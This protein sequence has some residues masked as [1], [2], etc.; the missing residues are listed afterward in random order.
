MAVLTSKR[1]NL[2]NVL[3]QARFCHHIADDFSFETFTD[4]FPVQVFPFD[5]F[6]TCSRCSHSVCLFFYIGEMERYIHKAI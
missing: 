4:H 6:F 3:L 5:K 1:T 2:Q